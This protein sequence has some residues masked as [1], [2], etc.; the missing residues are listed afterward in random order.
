MLFRRSATPCEPTPRIAAVGL[1]LVLL[2]GCVADDE[3]DNATADFVHASNTL[4]QAY[5]S[6]LT[7]ANSIEA[8][9]YINNITFAA[10]NGIVLP[11]GQQVT[12]PSI[13]ASAV[14]TADEIRL[15]TDAVKVLADYTTAL[16]TL[17]S[18]KPATDIQAAAA[19]ASGSIKSLTADLTPFLTTPP[20]GTKAPDFA[21]PA[22]AAATAI[23]DVLKVIETHRGAAQVRDSI[24]ANN[25]AITAL[26]TKIESEATQF[27]RR[28][29]TG[30]NSVYI[31]VLGSYN[32]ALAAYNTARTAST[33]DQVH[34]AQ[35]QELVL[36]LG[37]QLLRSEKNLAAV[38]RADPSAAIQRFEKV[39]AALIDVINGSG[40]T[41]KALVSALV[42][43]VKSFV[44]EVK[45]P[46]KGSGTGTP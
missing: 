2:S 41:K 36:A 4:A 29:V 12:G 20:P 37:G 7:N 39:H 19:T 35:Q 44:A 24:K 14:L 10:V 33:V 40:A 23:G 3:I 42:S 25:P 13:A 1:L 5:Q 46:A 28:A 17:A 30:S 34:V 22:A 9:D 21:S 38:S 18:G 16:A 6:L 45:T 31:G 8:E 27:F 15:R 26:F 32:R 11:P 43:E